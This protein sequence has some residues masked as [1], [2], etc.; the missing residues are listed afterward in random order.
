MANITVEQVHS[1]N[2]ICATLKSECKAFFDAVRLRAYELF[3][4]NGKDPNRELARGG[5]GTARARST[6][7]HNGA[8]KETLRLAVAGFSRKDIEVYVIENRLMVKAFAG[9]Q[10]NTPSSTS[11]NY[12]TLLYQ[13]PLR[14]QANLA[15][16]EAKLQDD[17]LSI[18]VPFSKM[19]AL[20]TESNGAVAA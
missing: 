8:G 7:R 6:E 16:I 3:Q 17:A 11:E 20:A 12:R 10:I 9:E 5:T 13:H 19:G 1:H 2:A 4:R 15:E 14:C 18:T